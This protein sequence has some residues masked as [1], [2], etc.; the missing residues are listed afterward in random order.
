[1]TMSNGARIGNA[2]TYRLGARELLDFGSPENEK[3][4]RQ[5]S[6]RERSERS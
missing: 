2:M 6:L 4:S 1:M 3:G 5:P